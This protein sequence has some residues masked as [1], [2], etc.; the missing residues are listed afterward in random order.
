[1]NTVQHAEAIATRVDSSKVSFDPVTIITILTT[2]LPLIT[3]CFRRNDQPDPDQVSA[4]VRDAHERNPES[5]RRRT[6]RRIRG[7]AD[8]PMTKAEA[9]ELADAT[10]AHA[11]ETPAE[12]V[13]AYCRN[14]A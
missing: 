10:I 6:A 2:V 11:L 3:G 12:L 1:M 13:A 4:S 7:E 5:L 14:P 9:L 8:H